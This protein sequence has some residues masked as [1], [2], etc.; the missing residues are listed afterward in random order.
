MMELETIQRDYATKIVSMQYIRE[1]INKTHPLRAKSE[2][3]CSDT[4]VW[5]IL[6][7]LVTN[8]RA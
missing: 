2:E 1:R 4:Y 3:I 5:K 7:D 8:V 6:E